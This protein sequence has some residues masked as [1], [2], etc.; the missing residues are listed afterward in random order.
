MSAVFHTS[1]IWASMSSSSGLNKEC[2]WESTQ[3]S[4]N[5]QLEQNLFVC[6]WNCV[7][8]RTLPNILHITALA[9]LPGFGLFFREH[10]ENE[11]AILV[12]LEGRG[13]DGVLPRWK[14]E[15]VT[16]FPGVDEGA[17]HGHSSLSQQ[18]IWAE[19]KVAATLELRRSRKVLMGK[20]ESSF[21]VFYHIVNNNSNT[22]DSEANIS[23]TRG[24]D[25]WSGEHNAY[26]FWHL[27]TEN[28]PFFI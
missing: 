22:L 6:G 17:T 11:A 4:T 2:T 15:A 25:C 9:Q 19:V 16:H 26:L 24:A 18:D 13:N 27:Q 12:R 3:T 8:P 23:V 21:V 5:A 20:S 28:R 1:S 10:P 14:F 7:R